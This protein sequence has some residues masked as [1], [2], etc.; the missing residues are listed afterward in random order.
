M[1]FLAELP[2][3]QMIDSYANRFAPGHGEVIGEMLVLLRQA[4]TL[5]RQLD[6]YFAAHDLSQLKFLILIVI[7]REPD[8]DWLSLS[9]IAGRLDVSRP[10]VSRTVRA[11]VEGELLSERPEPTDKRSS[12][13][14]ITLKARARLEAVL[15]GYF[16]IIARQH[17]G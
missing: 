1:F 5:I 9:E 15:P 7:D 13:L 16:E 11:L 3:R 12:Q 17:Q 8:R 2:T 14:H 6:A 10:V 4:S